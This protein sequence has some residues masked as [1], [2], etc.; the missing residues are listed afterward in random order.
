MVFVS[1]FPYVVAVSLGFPYMESIS[2]GFPHVVML[3]SI[4]T[5]VLD[6][7]LL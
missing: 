7:A 2:L 4:Y 5:I 6:T 3:P 1:L